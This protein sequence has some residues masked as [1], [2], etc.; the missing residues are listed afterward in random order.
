MSARSAGSRGQMLCCAVLCC[1]LR[2]ERQLSVVGAGLPCIDVAA[3]AGLGARMGACICT[4]AALADQ[5]STAPPLPAL[6][7]QAE[8]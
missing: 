6:Q 4:Q 5:Q 3:D 2:W 8:A 7:R 1:M